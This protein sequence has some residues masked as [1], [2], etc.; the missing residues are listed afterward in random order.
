MLSLF[1]ETLPGRPVRFIRF[2][3][4]AICVLRVIEEYRLMSRVL[5]SGW[6]R[7]PMAEWL[8][9]ATKAQATVVLVLWLLSA[10]AF[11]AGWRTKI[12]GLVLAASMGYSLT[13][14]QQLYSSHLYL[15]TLIVLLLTLSEIARPDGSP[16]VWRWPILL[17]QIQLSLVYFFAAVTKMNSQY[18]SGY[19]LAENL[20]RELPA[21]IFNPRVLSAMAVT[22]IVVELTLA[23]SFWIKDL[24][25][26]AVVV[27]TLFHFTMVL[28]L[29]PNVA[30]QLAIFAA[31][32]I[33]IYPLF[34][35]QTEKHG[36]TAEQITE[37]PL[38]RGTTVGISES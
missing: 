29:A 13:L 6:L 1:S 22:S 14:D 10:L 4:G 28:S 24:R 23:V 12:T 3:I 34:F 26:G 38:D 18:L 16:S 33:A 15:L 37:T 35:V 27:G 36:P 2:V 19:M 32:C 30:G 21:M 20:R 11:M 17:L 7:F 31:A 25:K 8:P 9:A 5:Q